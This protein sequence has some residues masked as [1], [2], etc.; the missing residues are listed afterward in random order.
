MLLYTSSHQ[1]HH[2]N[3]IQ[4]N[5]KRKHDVV[6]VD[7]SSP[8]TS[9]RP[10]S[11]HPQHFNNLASLPTDERV[12]QAA[13]LLRM[14]VTRLR[15]VI[16]DLEEEEP[17]QEPEQFVPYYDWPL[18][19]QPSRMKRGMGRGR[20]TPKP[21]STGSVGEK[22][23]GGEMNNYTGGQGEKT[24]SQW[25]GQMDGSSEFSEPAS[26]GGRDST[27]C[28]PKEVLVEFFSN[29]CSVDDEPSRGNGYGKL[30]GETGRG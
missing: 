15:S 17:E 6:V 24:V 30:I 21:R 23:V 14:P 3:S 10:R 29:W 8:S 18:S 28:F 2:S 1:R 9:K 26:Q 16:S 5:R 7:P 13:T 19:H 20:R 22:A 25:N 27:F 11:I 4:A 12:R